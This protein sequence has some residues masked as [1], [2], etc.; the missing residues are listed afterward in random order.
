MRTSRVYR[1]WAA[2][3]TPWNSSVGLKCSAHTDPAGAEVAPAIETKA[4]ADHVLDSAPPPEWAA[5]RRRGRAGFSKGRDRRA[6]RH[7]HRGEEPR[8]PGR[9][10]TRRRP[11]VGPARP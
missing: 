4:A 3:A 7:S 10:N 1:T 9:D 5:V 2:S 6:G 8:V 11:R